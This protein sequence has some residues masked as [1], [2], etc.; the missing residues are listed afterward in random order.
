VRRPTRRPP[1]VAMRR[2]ATKPSIPPNMLAKGQHASNDSP[3]ATAAVRENLGRKAL[4]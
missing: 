4:A 2:Y 3:S 1:L